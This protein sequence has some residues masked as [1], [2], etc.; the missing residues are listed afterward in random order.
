[1]SKRLLATCS[2]GLAFALLLALPAGRIVRADNVVGTPASPSRDMANGEGAFRHLQALQEIANANGG[3]RAAGTPGHDRSAEYVATRLQEAGYAVRFEEFE[4]PYFEERGPP[5]LQAVA[6]D[7]RPEPVSTGAVRTLGNSGSGDVTVRLRA[8]NL[9]LGEGTPPASASGCDA[10]DFKEFELG[11]LALVR[12]GTCPF[13]VKV[14]NAVTAGAAGVVIMNE[15][16]D[17]RVDMFSGQLGKAAA[18][19]VVGI[20][21]EHG[22][23][24]AAAARADT[25]ARVHLAV[26]TATGKRPTRNVLA[27]TAAAGEGLLIV[28]GAH[29]DSVA[30]G[31]GIN[32]NGSGSAAVLEAALRLA[33]ELANSRVRF[34]F[35]SAEE[36]G[37]IGSRHHVAALSDAER[38][39]IAVYINLDMVGSPNFVRYVQGPTA[40]GAAAAAR[41]ELLADFRE[42]NLPVEDRI[43][44]RFGSDDATFSQ[45]NVPTIGLYTGAGGPKSETQATM[46]GGVAGRP[47]DAC[48]HRACDTTE[49]I[50]REVL[51]QSTHALMRALRVVGTPV[52]T[53][54]SPVA[55]PE[56]RP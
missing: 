41:R 12:R 48:Y 49:N 53:T 18:I 55:A 27:E 26:N 3:N 38:G 37:L 47:F 34:A 23:A 14:D 36:N 15:G 20:S 46:F 43:G 6:P 25:G 7:G 11:A 40:D 51:E 8:V 44:T 29:L 56:P 39:R 30:E 28:V 4:F 5:I 52:T 21:Y 22:R 2:T 50:N 33:K 24:L 45:K 35:W 42:S 17:G 19:P 54:P 31:P 13:Q 1:M 32:D 16:T 9:Q 10:A